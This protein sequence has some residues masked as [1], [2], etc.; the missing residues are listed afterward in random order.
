MG[1][2]TYTAEEIGAVALRLADTGLV[3]GA[4][5]ARYTDGDYLSGHG[6]KAW[7]K[8]PGA[9]TARARGLRDETTA[10]TFD[11]INESRISIDLDTHLVSAVALGDAEYSLDL[12]SFSRQVLRPQVDS[13]VDGI[14]AKVANVLDG[15]DAT[16]ESA[17]YDEAK[18]SAIFTKGRRALR[19]RGVD[20]AN[21]R[22]VAFVGGNVVDALLDS[23]SLDFAKTGDSDALRKG[24]LGRIAG[25]ECIETARGVGADEVVFATKSGVYLATKAPAIPEGANFGAVVSEQGL[26]LRYLRDYSAEHLRDRSVTSV[27]C[28]AGISPLYD[29]QR[30][31]A[32]GAATVTEVEGGA[33]VKLATA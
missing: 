25:F 3:L 31:Q 16:D 24:A 14:E 29:V 21:E 19:A 30:D 22:L 5:V 8:I 13:I 15:I 7:L 2:N 33:V 9:V 4:N 1:L 27:F 23:G 26:S 32:T 17:G 20:V 11:R 10:V 12:Q 6:G 28:G 18:P